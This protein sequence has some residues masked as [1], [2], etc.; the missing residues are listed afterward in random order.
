MSLDRQKTC[1]QSAFSTSTKDRMT[2]LTLMRAKEGERLHGGKAIV[3]MLR[4][5]HSY[6]QHSKSKKQEKNACDGKSRRVDHPS[7]EST[8][9]EARRYVGAFVDHLVYCSD[10]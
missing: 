8:A 7:F 6:M 2:I 5:I 4:T 10:G 1:L 3:N 9:S